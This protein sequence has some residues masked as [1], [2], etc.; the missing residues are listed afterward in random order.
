MA[1]QDDR[2]IPVPYTSR[3]LAQIHPGQTLVVH[4]DVSP[5]ANRFEI[6]LLNDCTE[7]NPNMG[8]VPLHV[9][10]RFDEG[11]I[12][13]NNLKGGEWG[14]EERH[15]NPLKKGEPFDIRIRVHEDKYEVSVNQKHLVD[16][17]HREAVT[18][19]DH[20]QVMGDVTLKGVHWGGRYFDNP[21]QTHF[22]NGSLKTG[23]RVYVY[24]VPKGD[25]S[26]NFLGGN[27][28][29]LF[30][31]NPRFSEKQV[32][33][34]SCQGGTW[35]NEEREGHF[36]FKKEVGFDLAVQNEPYSLQLFL[37]G[38]RIGT[39]AHRA[40]PER[41][42]QALRIEGQVEITGVEVSHR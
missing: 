21:F 11:K 40:N 1:H 16:F 35:G 42:Y 28:D 2:A 14:K 33:R 5:S 3:L 8:S 23:Q 29:I 18:A 30:H 10:V 17:K 34:N 41:D 26:V 24:G 37:N 36:P 4:G 32:V 25:F 20:L 19:V 7:I 31:F 39:F 12:V 38:E 6:N 15:S 22:H 13:L 9:N 27:G